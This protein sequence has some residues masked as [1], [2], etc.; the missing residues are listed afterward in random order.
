[1]R[2]ILALLFIFGA[3]YAAAQTANIIPYQH[4]VQIQVGESQ[5]VHG[6]R[7][8]CGQ[9]PTPSNSDPKSTKLGVLT[10]GA[11]GVRRSGRCGGNTPA[12]EVIFTAKK[13]G[14]EQLELFGDRIDIT[15]SK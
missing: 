2:S 8:E 5:V 11:E 10:F 7:G 6:L 15:V 3:V 13:A 9:L 12:I 1:M 4:D 14:K